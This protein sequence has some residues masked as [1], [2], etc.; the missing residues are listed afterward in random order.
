MS[1]IWTMDIYLS[2]IIHIHIDYLKKRILNS[3]HV[4]KNKEILI[5]VDSVSESYLTSRFP[6]LNIFPLIHLSCVHAIYAGILFA[7]DLPP[8]RR[9]Q[10]KSLFH[11]KNSYNKFFSVGI[12]L[13]FIRVDQI[14]LHT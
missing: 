5:Q 13:C 8:F 14:K 3:G 10:K 4:K 9:R 6:S 7:V 1:I 11:K 2:I 12:L